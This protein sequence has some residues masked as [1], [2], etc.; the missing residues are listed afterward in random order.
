MF[1]WFETLEDRLFTGSRSMPSPWGPVLRVA[2]YPAALIRDWLRGEISV[3]AMSLAYTTL[4]SIVPLLVFSAVILK[5]LGARGDLKFIISQFF[6]PM[7]GAAD[8][9]TESVLQFVRN[10]RGDL[11][12]AI[13]LIFLVYTVVT[14]IQKVETSFNFLWRVDRPRS[15]LRRFSE[16]L[17]VMVLGPILLAV[18]LGL[19][20]SAERSPFAAWVDGIKPLAWTLSTVGKILPYVIVT[21]IFTFMYVFI[22]NT[23]V[24]FRAALI[25]GIAS[26]IVW[27]LVGKIFTAFIVYSS[28][29]VA[30]YT[31]FAIV[32]TTL[33]W[34][35][36]SW[37]I[38]LIGAQFAFYLQFPQYLRH[39][40]ESFELTGRDREQVALSI[41][42]LIGRD[43]S[44]GKSPW[45]ARSLAAE[46]DIPSIALAPVMH[47]LESNGLILAT[48]KQQFVP[49]RDIAAIALSEIF[50]VVRALHSGRLAVAIRSVVPAVALLNEVE[51]SM[52]A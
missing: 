12:G 2:R 9:L 11:L 8:Q 26:G 42:Y 21:I 34:V 49:G 23:K 35:Y 10:M 44:E 14:T 50:E 16:Y 17:A 1:K 36:V 4:L 20:A 40:Q 30:I 52:E 28:S 37:L 32:L 46:L 19:L 18:A 51:A 25:G 41:M 45:S 48:E 3:R 31:G 27:A 24:Q 5:S 39:G 33:V 6:A 43:Y 15:F 7:G 29:W 47:C 22:P 13:G 38:M